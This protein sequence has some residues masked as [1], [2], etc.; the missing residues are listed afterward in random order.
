MDGVELGRQIRLYRQNLPVLLTSGYAN[1]AQQAERE[2]FRVLS[3]P[4]DLAALD[5]A[6]RMA[7]NEG[8]LHAQ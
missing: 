4:Y 7:R 3:K 8:S 1:G 2:G 6:L 5:S